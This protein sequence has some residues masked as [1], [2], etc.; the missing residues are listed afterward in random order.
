MI[1]TGAALVVTG[2][3]VIQMTGIFYESYRRHCVPRTEM[4][5][6]IY[7]LN[8]LIGPSERSRIF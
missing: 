3:I 7:M 2:S 1:V 5:N 4:D 8:S 6:G